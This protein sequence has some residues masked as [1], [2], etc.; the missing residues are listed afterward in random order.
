MTSALEGG[1]GSASN[2][3]RYLPPGKT[4]YQFYRRQGG[5][6][7]RSG[8]VRKISPPPV[9]DLRTVQSV[10]SRYTNYA[11]WPTPPG[12]IFKNSTWCSLCVEWFV[13]ISEQ[14]TTFALYGINRLVFITVVESVYSAVRTNSLY[15]A[16][17]IESL[18][19][20]CLSC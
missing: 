5:P 15:K 17:Y 4:R 3:G 10:A 9:F 14:T 16:D 8:Q 6:Q 13:R 7:G 18:K 19:C 12:L 1:E 2:P 20:Y 11:T